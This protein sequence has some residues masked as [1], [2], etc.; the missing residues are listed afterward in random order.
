MYGFPKYSYTGV[1]IH[2]LFAEKNVYSDYPPCQRD[3]V[4]TPTMQQRFIDS[5]LRGLP[6]PPITVL[7][8]S[9]NELMGPRYWIVDGQQR[10]KT[11]LKYRNNEFKTAKTFRQE[12][13]IAPVE[14][15]RCYSELTP[16]GKNQFDFYEL[17][18][19]KVI[20]DVTVDSS[21]TGL[22]YRRL[23]NQIKLS[24]AERLY[25]YESKAKEYSEEIT[26][27]RFWDIIYDGKKDR[28]QLF[29]MGLLVLRMEVMSPF[30]NLTNPQLTDLVFGNKDN[31]LSK[32]VLSSIKSTLTGIEHVLY[33][34]SFISTREIIAIY[35]TGMLLQQDRYDLM[36]SKRGCLASWYMQVKEKNA[37]DVQTGMPDL[38]TRM[39]KVNQQVQFWQEQLPILISAEGLVQKDAK[40]S[41]TELDRIRAWQR[42]KGKC[43]ECGKP[44]RLG[45]T[46]HH[47]ISFTSGGKTD[48]TNC[49]LLHKDCH[50][51]LHAQPRL[52]EK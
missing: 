22:A 26:K 49:V 38:Y 11:I 6:I 13:G 1:P 43:L 30:V 51:R 3:Y 34:A 18:I 23:N 47:E 25:S 39:Q 35:Q 44:I 32:D 37:V 48:A 2:A 7:P 8:A 52:V 42:Q 50:E 16:A 19:C 40:R 28:K 21:F 14:P 45:D 17:Q 9:A 29:L 27:H 5:I 36:K 20:V 15:G 24:L 10:M 4:W 33:G 31:L 46:A 41:F 12:P